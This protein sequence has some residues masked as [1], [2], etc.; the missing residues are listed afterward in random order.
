MKGREF[1]FWAENGANV[2]CATS[3]CKT[4]QIGSFQAI[5]DHF[6]VEFCRGSG[7]FDFPAVLTGPQRPFLRFITSHTNFNKKKKFNS[8]IKVFRANIQKCWC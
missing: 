6:G 8:I 5:L 4:S 1:S 2:E 7:L 3:E